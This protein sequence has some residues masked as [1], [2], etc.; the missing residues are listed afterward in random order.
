M[1]KLK[2]D[3]AV[4]FGPACSCSQTLETVEPGFFRLAFDYVDRRPGAEGKFPRFELTSA[5]V[6]EHFAVRDYRTKA[7]IAAYR[8][9][10][11][12]KRWAKYNAANAWQYSWR[13]LIS[14]FRKGAW[15]SAS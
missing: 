11:Q 4:S 6:A 15:Q 9:K 2:Y 1:S 13:K 7:E 3:L 14:H 10:E 8:L 5:A 12:R